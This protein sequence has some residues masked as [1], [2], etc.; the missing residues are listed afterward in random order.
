MSNDKAWDDSEVDSTR[1][2]SPLVRF[3]PEAAAGMYISCEDLEWIVSLEQLQK[4]GAEPAS[5]CEWNVEG[6]SVCWFSID[7]RRVAKGER[8]A[9]GAYTWTPQC[10]CLDDEDSGGNRFKDWDEDC[11]IHGRRASAKTE[12]R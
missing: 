4:W 1:S 10:T 7:G 2:Y 11:P 9:D 8:S 5:I 3:T 6:P 12:T